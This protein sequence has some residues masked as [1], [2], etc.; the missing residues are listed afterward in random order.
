MRATARRRSGHLISYQELFITLGK[1][2]GR[3]A[4]YMNALDTAG[5]ELIKMIRAKKIVTVVGQRDVRSYSPPAGADYED[6][7]PAILEHPAIKITFYNKLM[8]DVN[9]PRDE[10]EGARTSFSNVRFSKEEVFG[11]L[12][13]GSNRAH[14]PT[15]V[16]GGKRG[17]KSKRDIPKSVLLNYL[18][19]AQGKGGPAPARDRLVGKIAGEFPQYHVT[20]DAVRVVHKEVFGALPPGKRSGRP[21]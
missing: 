21:D 2:L 6:I 18:K 10:W 20:R 3:V 8:M 16:E 14:D 19:I 15:A 7:P 17:P 5:S 1:E 13:Q 12:P 11:S 4:A 9:L